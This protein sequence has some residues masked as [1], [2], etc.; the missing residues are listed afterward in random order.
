MHRNLFRCA[1]YLVL[2]T[3]VQLSLVHAQSSTS[4][5]SN[6]SSSSAVSTSSFTTTITTTSGSQ[7]SV[8]TSVIP[9][10]VAVNSS[11]NATATSNS[12]TSQSASPSATSF[13]LDTRIDPGFGVLGAILII[14]GLPSAFWGHKNRWSSF[15][16]IGFYTFA[17]ACLALILKFGVL[18]AVNPPTD[19]IRGVFVFACC[20]AGFAGG[21]VAIFF[22][23]QAKYFIGAWGG[24][25]FG[26]WVQSFR[27]GGLIRPVGFRW[28]L[29]I[30]L[31]VVGFCVCTLPKVHY[32][33]LLASTAAVGA[34][35]FVLGIDCFTTANLKEFYVWNLGF[36][37]LFPKFQNNGIQFP[38]SQMMQIELGLIGAFT[39]MGV[40][41][42]LR[43]LKILQY[44]LK[45][46]SRE[47]N[48]RNEE[49]EAQAASRF[50]MTAKELADWEK[51]HGRVDSNLS[52]LPL[53]RDEE[54]QSPGTEEASTLIMGDHRRSR[55]QS[56][57]SD[58]MAPPDEKRQNSGALPAI[59][60]GL[61]LEADIPRDFVTDKISSPSTESSKVLSAK[62]REDLKKKEELM[63]EIST[64]RKSIEQ[65][66]S[67]TPGSS[68]EGEHSRHQ[69]FTSRRTLSLGF[70][71]AME[72]PTRPPRSLDPHSADPRSRV[73]SMDRLSQTPD[74]LMSGTS[75]SRPSSAPLQD[76]VQ[77]NEYVRE[78]KLFQPPGGP[79]PPIITTPVAPQPRHPP[80]TV[81]N[82]VSEAL[83]RRQQQE[84]AFGT[85]EF[86]TMARGQSGSHTSSE[87]RPLSRMFSPPKATTV[88]NNTRAPVTILPP[89]KP[90][91][92]QQVR[93]TAPRTYTFEELA[94]RHREK[95]HDLQAPLSRAE[96]EHAKLAEARIRWERSKEIERQV[97][98][99]KQAEK[100]AAVKQRLEEKEEKASGV[101]QQQQQQQQRSLS[102]DKLGRLPGASTSKR[103]SMLKV[104]DWRRFQQETDVAGP[105]HPSSKRD[106][107]VPFPAAQ[108]G[109]GPGHRQSSSNDRRRSQPLPPS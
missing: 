53:L 48:R 92:T 97:M 74:A 24:F 38:I 25:A 51:D 73:Q 94:E 90:D 98:S 6:S 103:Q 76:D 105:A 19:A 63:A 12:T 21:G 9:T 42:Q 43:V 96:G 67:A 104:E 15:F 14:T 75:I 93:P 30:G 32:H 36:D 23:Q 17:L 72:G 29:Y 88:G 50:T 26:L 7:T 58:F 83:M 100:A 101:K 91:A 27:A 18:E 41:V 89:R 16:L 44:K 46:I 59:D 31:G 108:A 84:A 20:I 86:G 28:I 95:L 60:L 40:A 55:Y 8:I 99:K 33:V 47:Q 85:G 87:E 77:W 78:R 80:L 71:E 5:S 34:S 109:R 57:I 52:G 45:E 49:L 2:A 107:N 3:L 64:I 22:W 37:S 1:L 106:S 10:T 35:A 65:L 54:A 39:L 79:S 56:G 62:E 61:D 102:A 11:A 4:A 69:S 82:A 68:G 70:A 66:R 13:A 81:P